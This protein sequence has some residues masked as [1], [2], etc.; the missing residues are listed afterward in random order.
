MNDGVKSYESES[1]T[2]IRKKGFSCASGTS[3]HTDLWGVGCAFWSRR[4]NRSIVIYLHVYIY[5]LYRLSES[6]PVVSHIQTTSSLRLTSF[7]WPALDFL[8][9]EW[10][11]GMKRSLRISSTF[12][13]VFCTPPTTVHLPYASRRTAQFGTPLLLIASYERHYYPWPLSCIDSI[14]SPLFLSCRLFFQ[15]SNS[16]PFERC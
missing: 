12:H 4:I 15:C 11:D 1:S 3:A 6:K 9:V 5:G 14:Y 8:L 7:K 2:S 16:P 10:I 13:C